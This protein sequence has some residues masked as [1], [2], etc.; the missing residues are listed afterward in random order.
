MNKK[1]LCVFA[2]LNLVAV[3]IPF[4]EPANKLI[5]CQNNLNYFVDVNQFEDNKINL[6][7]SKKFEYEIIRDDYGVPHVFADTKEALAFGT[8]YA[9]AQDRLWQADVFRRQ[10]TGRLAEYNLTSVDYDYLTRLKGYSKQE[11]TELF[12][13]LSSPYKEMLAAYTEGINLYINEA[14][15][16]PISKMPFE[17]LS[18]G[19]SPEPWTVEDSMAIGQMMVRR[20]GEGG[21]NELI[22]TVGHLSLIERNGIIKGWRIFND[23]CPQFDPGSITT[24]DCDEYFNNPRISI[25]PPFF[26]FKVVESAKKFIEMKKLDKKVSESLGLLYHFGS[27]AWVVSTS[28]SETGNALLLGGP[29]MGHTIPQIVVEIGMH[30]AGINA[31]GMTFPGVGPAIAIGVSEYGAWTT[32]SGL[33]DGVDTY[34]EILHP[35]NK[36]K[37]L[38]KNKWL[39]MERR[40]ETI[41]DNEGVAHEFEFYRSV[42]GPVL[43][44]RWKPFLGGIAVSQKMAFWKNEHRTLEGVMSFQECKNISEFEQGVSKIVSSHNWFWA[45]RNGDI[46]YYHS[47]WYPIRPEYGLFHRL[48]DDRFPLIGTGKEEWKGIVPFVELPKGRNPSKG[49]YANWNN[50]PKLNWPYAEAEIGPMWGEGHIVKRIMELLEADDNISFEDMINICRNVAYHNAYGTY[51]KPYLLDAIY[52][53]GGIPQQV[54]SALEDWN[55][56]YNDENNDG[57]YDEPGLT[58]FNKWYDEIFNVILKDELI[59]EVRDFT[60]SLLLHIFQGKDSKLKLRYKNYLGN[61][62]KEQAIII[63]L[64]NTLELLENQF[65]TDNISQWLTPVEMNHFKEIGA[66][67]SPEMPNMNRGTYNQIAEMPNYNLNSFFSPIAYNVLPPGQNGFVNYLGEPNIHAYDQL[68]LYVN[69]QFKPMLFTLNSI[70]N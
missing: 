60:H 65:G 24:L 41:Y 69:W 61:L 11:N 38:F 55:C 63:A 15:N 54:I 31:T 44:I 57:F 46:G 25:L 52:S 22:F 19:I 50:K 43:D 28:K 40:I 13:N 18:K 64:K 67:P 58:I 47:G 12:E 21:G 8:G 16:N 45:D 39:S 51:F 26:I 35:F 49:F 30:G 10:A 68:N 20:W 29:Q 56:Y 14:L 70:N 23:L 62:S 4:L 36:T 9:I 27:N 6:N 3:S 53:V 37:Y 59:E 32:T 34:I 1:I 42:H 66:L 17:Y 33:S 5:C 48:I 7:F 2:V